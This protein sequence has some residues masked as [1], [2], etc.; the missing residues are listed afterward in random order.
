MDT[1]PSMIFRGPWC[2]QECLCH[3]QFLPVSRLAIFSR[4][5][6]VNFE[7]SRARSLVS[8]PPE[9]CTAESLWTFG[10]W[11]KVYGLD[12]A[13]LTSMML[14]LANAARQG[15]NLMWAFTQFVGAT[16]GSCIGSRS[17]STTLCHGAYVVP[18]YSTHGLG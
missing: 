9:N 1:D 14:E 13:F 18:L 3:G 4:D 15:L 11:I 7:Y 6:N 17:Q 2:D 12:N 16:S 5:E 8:L 10:Q